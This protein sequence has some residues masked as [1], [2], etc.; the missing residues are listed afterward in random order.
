MNREFWTGKALYPTIALVVI[1][2]LVLLARCPMS[3]E[4]AR[5]FTLPVV[6]A[7]GS[8]GPDRMR[9]ADS[10]GHVVLIDF[11]ATW[12]G[13]CR[14]SIPTLV[15]L[16]HRF[17]SR[18]LTVIGISVDAEPDP[19]PDFM[20]SFRM[21][22]PVLYD[23]LGVGGSYNVRGLPTLVLVDRQGRIRRTITGEPDPGDLTRE[24]ESLL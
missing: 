7:Q 6:S 22:Y 20:R 12:C 2:A 14:R 5:D 18:G 13:P 11:W 23:N 17:R 19:V 15:D 1:A 16:S 10:R 24:V 8:V 21:D 3:Y 9:L 4:Q